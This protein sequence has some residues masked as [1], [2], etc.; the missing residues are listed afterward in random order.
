MK[1]NK[2]E[3]MSKSDTEPMKKS[4]MNVRKY[5]NYHDVKTRKKKEKKTYCIDKVKK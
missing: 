5:Q 1:N 2:Y 3:S 4:M